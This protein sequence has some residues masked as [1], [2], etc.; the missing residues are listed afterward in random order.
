MT[1]RWMMRM[2]RVSLIA[3]TRAL[4]KT[5]W[6]NQQLPVGVVFFLAQKCGTADCPLKLLLICRDKINCL[7]V[8]SPCLFSPFT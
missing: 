5:K 1:E 4:I 3:G 7:F 8:T 2:R 6:I